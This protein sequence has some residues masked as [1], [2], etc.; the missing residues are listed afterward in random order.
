MC[1][2]VLIR[3]YFCEGKVKSI[4]WQKFILFG[5]TAIYQ[6]EVNV[7]YRGKSIEFLTF[8]KVISSFQ[9]LRGRE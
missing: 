1:L 4:I 9:G 8:A 6:P 7:W 3:G 2:N 5:L